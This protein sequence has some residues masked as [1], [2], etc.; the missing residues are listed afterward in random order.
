MKMNLLTSTL[1]ISVPGVLPAFWKA[2]WTVIVREFLFPC[3]LVLVVVVGAK[4]VVRPL[5][6][7]PEQSWFNEIINSRQ[8]KHH[9]DTNNNQK[10]K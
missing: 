7:A 4:A 3:E 2:G 9:D 6:V 1:Q 10:Q 5:V 8:L